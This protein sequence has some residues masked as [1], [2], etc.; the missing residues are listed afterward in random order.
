MSLNNAISNSEWV[1]IAAGE[2]VMGSP[3]NEP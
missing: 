2:F 3:E 1:E